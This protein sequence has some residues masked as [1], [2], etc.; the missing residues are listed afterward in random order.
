M[1]GLEHESNKHAP[2]EKREEVT[3]K[4]FAMY[5]SDKNGFIDKQEWLRGIHR[6]ERLPDFGLGP[7]HH[8]DD[9]YEYEIHHFEKFHGPGKSDAGAIREFGSRGLMKWAD[10]TEADLTHPEDIE[11]FAK[12]DKED[13]AAEQWDQLYQKPII[14]KNIPAMFR[15]KS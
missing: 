15:R 7:G 8:G 13:L 6:G 10:T 9:E 11:H 12:H 14:Q 1:Y 2:H 3:R 4:I 5:D